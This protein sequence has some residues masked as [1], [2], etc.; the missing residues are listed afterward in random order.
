MERR[1][2]DADPSKQSKARVQTDKA[3]GKEIRIF[4]LESTTGPKLKII[5]T[6]IKDR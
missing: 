1:Q 5:M 4:L 2:S 3:F 6:R